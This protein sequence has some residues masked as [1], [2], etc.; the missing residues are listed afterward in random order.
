QPGGRGSSTGGQREFVEPLA[1]AALAV[2]CAAVFMET[3]QDPDNAPCDGPNMV[4][5]QA[6]DHLLAGLKSIDDLTKGRTEA[7]NAIF[8]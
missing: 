5:V 4:P 8:A 2:G 7:L 1:R 3:H 6:L